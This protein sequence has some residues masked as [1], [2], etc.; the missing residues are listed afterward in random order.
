MSVA[1]L[2]VA[3][4]LIGLALVAIEVLIVPG[5]GAVGVLGGLSL[6]GAGALAWF[7]LGRTEGMVAIALAAGGLAFLFW[8]LPRSRAARSLVLE[9]VQQGSAAAPGL[10]A[11]LGKEGHTLTPLRPSGSAE[12]DQLPVD[13]VAD[14]VF[15]EAGVRVKVVQVEGM[16]VV[17]EPVREYVPTLPS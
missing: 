4:F 7:K 6:L 17:V 14:G 13:V 1:F 8:Y 16:R 5:F 10:A 3:L 9:E 12:F 15:V 2:V 11:L